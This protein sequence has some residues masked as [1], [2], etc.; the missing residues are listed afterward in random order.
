MRIARI[1]FLF[2]ATLFTLRGIAATITVTNA[3]DN[4]PG[5]LREALG[6]AS[7]GDTIGFSV[8][9]TITL[10]NGELAVTKSLLINGPGAALL[11]IERSSAAGTPDFR[12]FNVDAGVV[13]IQGLTIRNGRADSGGG[14]HNETT[15]NLRSCVI[16][17]NFASQRG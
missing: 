15:F 14:V 6:L 7:A 3:A 8:N 1:S 9:G 11:T 2:I 12:I 17:G 10:T 16:V 5:S 13:T 4:G